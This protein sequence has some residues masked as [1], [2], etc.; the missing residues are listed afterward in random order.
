MIF[1]II[2]FASYGLPSES[3]PNVIV[4]LMNYFVVP[5]ATDI[6]MV[7]VTASVMLGRSML[8]F[9]P[10][11]EGAFDRSASLSEWVIPDNFV[12]FEG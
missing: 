6:R 10:L 5:K 1:S 7:F 9:I 11:N 3:I 2:S 8:E 4:A 12:A